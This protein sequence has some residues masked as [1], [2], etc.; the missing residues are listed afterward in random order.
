MGYKRQLER[1][2]AIAGVLLSMLVVCP[3]AFAQQ[4][5]TPSLVEIY[6]Q[7][8]KTVPAAGIT[9]LII[10][11]PDIAKAEVAS[12]SIQFF[13]LER[14][15][16]VALGYRNGDPV[17]IRIRVIPRPPIIVSPAALRRQSE[18]AQGMVGSNVQV[19]NG[20]GNT[21]IS[22]L[23]TFSW[24]QLAASD[25]R[26][27]IN[28]QVED[29]DIA[30]GHTFNIR[31]GAVS[32]VN[33]RMQVQA[34]DYIVS[35]TDNGP[36]HYL[37]PFSVS[38]SVELRGA[39]LTLKRGDNQY[40][41]FGGTTIPFFYLTLG[42]TRDIGGF[43]FVHKQSKKLSF[44]ATTTYINTPTNF[45]GFSG[46]RQ[47]DYMQT[48]GF[49]YQLD[50]KWTFRGTGG[51]SNHGGLGRAEVDYITPR[52]TFFAAG[53]LSSPLF[54][55]NQ[56][57]SLFSG[58]TSLKSGLTLKTSDRFTESVYYQHAI[59]QAI[60]NLLHAG[61]SDYLTPALSWRL[62]RSQDFNFSYT[63]SRNSGGFAN[64]TSTG[65]RFDS[66]WRY[67]FTPQLSNTAEVVVGSLQDPLQLNSED[68]LVL[69]DGITFPVKGGSMQIEFQHD[70][71]NP[72][73]IE[74]LNSEL[75]LLSPALQTL[76]LQ[77][78]VSFVNSG[79]VP[80]EVKAL[81]DAEVPI[82]TSISASGQFRLG[83]KLSF[84]P[85]FTLARATSGTT[86][87]WTPYVG[88]SLMYQATRT[89]QFNSGLSNVWVFTSSLTPQRTTIFSFGFNKTFSAMPVSS[90]LP[91]FHSGRMI[92]GR[93]FRD[94]NLNGVFNAGELGLVGVRVELDHGEV[95]TTDEQGRYRFTGVGGGEHRVY[96]NLA[97]F[98]GPVRMTTR[99][100]IEL[101]MIRERTAI[102]DFGVVD[103]ARLMGNI[104][105]DLRFEGKRQMDSRGLG[106]IHLTLDDGRH[107]RNLTV[108][109]NGEYETH[110]VPPGDY[111]LI[112]DT[113][114]LPANYVLPKNSFMV[115]VPPVSTV[116]QDIPARALRS[117]SGRIFLKI[118]V[119]SNA[120]PADP[121]KLKIGGVPQSSVRTQRG[122]QAGGKLG[123]AGGQV[124]RQ[125]QQG[126]GGQSNLPDYNLV[127][128]AG[129]QL[130]AGYGVAT[131]DENGNFL[132]RDLPAGD[133]TISVIPVKPLSPDL[134]VPSGVVHMP[135]EPIEVRGA[136]IVISNPDLVPYLVAKTADEI[137]NAAVQPLSPAPQ[138]GTAPPSSAGGQ[139]SEKTECTTANPSSAEKAAMQGPTPTSPTLT[140]VTP[141]GAEAPITYTNS[142]S[143]NGEMRG[144]ILR[145]RVADK[146]ACPQ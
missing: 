71:R 4:D 39:A 42:S 74:K 80:P 113:A 88:Y 107:T 30:G 10:L 117:I 75:N 93:V 102:V 19:F 68:E 123:Q 20:A 27:D 97:Q 25:G 78:P 128:M 112:V 49:T 5:A 115:H 109:P 45:L 64:Q 81:L 31:H 21:A 16:T 92:Q 9:N 37:S 91:V 14:G 24:S 101:D 139:S 6:W 120:P 126:T 130:S 28:T 34:L 82:N 87:S 119:D 90:V 76:F 84:A 135:P 131:S 99:N 51:A 104:F 63:F 58:T 110:D 108:E 60:N 50:S 40:A 72:S 26:L 118:I 65:N 56:V 48:A 38:D 95:A 114:S 141:R 127:P 94:G 85:N 22:A 44:F 3:S 146:P 69:R 124:T 89:L 33:P 86:Q 73:V 55:L 134:K 29:N 106:G 144:P 105:N 8:S 137:R 15:E 57:F 61:S 140:A 111:R 1:T 145:S 66:I 36:Q 96:V 2:A 67:Q 142:D 41:F 62:N 138:S 32:F 132:L 12:D 11:D 70:R 47:N 43:S 83:N 7:S 52:L 77:D 59:T 133:L 125:G 18:M 136:T 103:F 129:I 122:G 54:P 143:A 98:H 23:N 13:G 100:Q 79:N 53:S 35:L 46:Q 17:S 121:G 116:V